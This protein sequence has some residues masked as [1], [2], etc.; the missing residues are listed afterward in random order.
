MA[1]KAVMAILIA[2]L[3]VVGGCIIYINFVDKDQPVEPE[4]EPEVTYYGI[5]Y[6]LNGG[7]ADPSSPSTYKAGTVTSLGTPTKNVSGISV[8]FLGWYTDSAFTHRIYFIS[9]D[10]TG[11]ITVYAKWENPEFKVWSITYELNGG[12]QA[13]PLPTQYVEGKVTALGTPVKV[14]D[15]VSYT[16]EGWALDK[17]LTIIITE[18]GEDMTGDIKLYASWSLPKDSQYYPIEYVLNGG[19]ADPSS[20]SSYRVGNVTD[21][22]CPTKKLGSDEE[23]L[24]MGWY[25]DA[26]CTKS[27]LYIPAD[28]KG[29]ITLFALWDTDLVGHGF[30]FDTVT[31]STQT[32][33]GKEYVTESYGTFAYTYI[34]YDE[35]DGYLQKRVTGTLLKDGTYSYKESVDWQS[36]EDK[37]DKTYYE[38]GV[39]IN[40]DGW[41]PVTEKVT[42]VMYGGL[43]VEYQYYVYGWLLVKLQSEYQSSSV[44]NTTE[45]TLTDLLRY[46]SQPTYSINVYTDKGLTVYGAGTVDAY[47]KNVVLTVTA[48]EGTE[49]A[50]WYDGDGNRLSSKTTYVIEL[51]LSDITLFAMNTNDMDY[52]AQKGTQFTLTPEQTLKE[53]EWILK[54][55]SEVEVTR[56]YTATFAYTF[57]ECGKYSLAYYGKDSSGNAVSKIA[58]II[59]DGTETKVFE[60][61]N[62][63]DSY[64]V[65][66]DIL[67]SD[68][69]DYLSADVKR[70]QYSSSVDVKFVTYNDKYVKSVASQIS[71]QTKGVSEEERVTVLLR[72]VQTIPYVTDSE[73]R[74]MS[75]YFKF[76]LETLYDNGGDCEDTTFLFCAIGKAMGYDVAVMYFQGHAAA[77]INMKVLGYG[78]DNIDTYVSGSSRTYNVLK[79][80]GKAVTYLYPGDNV[81]SSGSYYLYCETTSVSDADGNVFNVGDV[82][83]YKSGSASSNPYSSLNKQSV[84]QVV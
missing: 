44:L 5:T 74:G 75:E 60:W 76:P 51:V 73:S 61:S 11:N 37:P 21:L 36:S 26:A 43:Y 7:T 58:S 24:F 2:A 14:K 1:Y 54:D 72:F 29:A 35:N 82:P 81:L 78:D 53:T 77:G 55:D 47:S 3:A 41:K 83:Y 12:T 84:I 66:L 52:T 17:E 25:L 16:F 10:Q 34:H 68:Y 62:G 71:D 15:S 6:V 69:N 30:Q 70:Y 48:D 20:P 23:Y 50:G 31:T 39:T 49:F 67:Y 9:A 56:Q 33:F 57:D 28:M 45:Y 32:W 18:I 38:E 46:E 22:G 59:V 19:T 42:V 79:V 8:S 27:I 80:D 64:T 4:P 65:T 63:D 40:I 13:D